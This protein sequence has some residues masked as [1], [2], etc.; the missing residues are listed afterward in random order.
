AARPDRQPAAAVLRLQVA[1][2]ERPRWVDPD[3]AVDHPARRAA[4]RAV[5][6]VVSARRAVTAATGCD[7]STGLPLPCTKHCQCLSSRGDDR[8]ERGAHLLN[9]A[10]AICT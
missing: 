7:P 6:R 3:L 1:R 4:R 5:V 9:G 8:V 10:E 2:G